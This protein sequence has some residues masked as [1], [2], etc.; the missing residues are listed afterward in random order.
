MQLPARCG[1]LRSDGFTLVELLV[2]MA[3][4]AL[5]AA[6]VPVAFGKL[7]ETTEYRDTVR[8]VLTD[9]RRARYQARDSGR[10]VVFGVNLQ[11]RTFGVEG[12]AAHQVPDA[13]D[14]RAAA[15]A[16]ESDP[17][18]QYL[19]IRF[20][21]QGGATG[22]S[23]DLIRSSGRGVRLRVDWFSGRVEQEAIEP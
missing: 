21:P 4:M 20:L 12:G 23:L 8:A 18:G 5:I 11:E 7:S 6:V 22:G 3:I 15:A 14:L 2:V 19:G 9:M 17:T 13:L 1:L 10:E 16:R